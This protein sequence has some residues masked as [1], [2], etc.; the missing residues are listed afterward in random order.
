MSE[1]CP[2]C[3]KSRARADRDSCGCLVD[4]EEIAF[5]PAP[6]GGA[7]VKTAPDEVYSLGC[8]L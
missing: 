6:Y 5:D 3:G 4:T 8:V 2:N 7:S 1:I